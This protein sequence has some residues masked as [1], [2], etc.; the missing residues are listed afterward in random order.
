[1][2][3]DGHDGAHVA[4][5]RAP[6]TNGSDMEKVDRTQACLVETG[7]AVENACVKPSWRRRLHTLPTANGSAL[8]AWL[9]LGACSSGNSHL[10]AQ[11]ATTADAGE[12]PAPDAA[13]PA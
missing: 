12:Q 1:M 3:Y 6:R 7:A 10:G 13:A 9:A 11:T 2:V 8:V 4:S 5:R